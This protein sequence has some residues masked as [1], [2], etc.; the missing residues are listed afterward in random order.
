MLLI[1]QSLRYTLDFYL[2]YHF[3]VFPL[4]VSLTF[5]SFCQVL[6]IPSHSSG[7]ESDGVSYRTDPRHQ[8]FLVSAQNY[9]LQFFFFSP[10]FQMLASLSTIVIM[11][12]LFIRIRFFMIM[13]RVS[14]FN[15]HFVSMSICRTLFPITFVTLPVIVYVAL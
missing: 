2:P 15:K 4:K 1:L 13:F 5:S 7:H 3:I 9:L 10:L 11:S 8:G 14:F 12:T 6:W